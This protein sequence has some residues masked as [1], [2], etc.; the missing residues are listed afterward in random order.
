MQRNYEFPTDLSEFG[1][2]LEGAKQQVQ[3]GLVDL[4]FTLQ[5]LSHSAVW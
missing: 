3:A 4:Q 2:R 1:V 5:V